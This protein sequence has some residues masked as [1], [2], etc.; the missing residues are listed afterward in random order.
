MNEW[1][2][3]QWNL[4]TVPGGGRE[5]QWQAVGWQP[6]A[7][8]WNGNINAAVVVDACCSFDNVQKICTLF[9]AAEIGHFETLCHYYSNVL[10]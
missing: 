6:K 4:G 7:V 2:S 3:L 10:E 1:A 9:S 5:S 8:G